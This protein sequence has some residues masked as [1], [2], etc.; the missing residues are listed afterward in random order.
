MRTACFRGLGGADSMLKTRTARRFFFFRVSRIRVK[1]VVQESPYRMIAVEPWRR[2]LTSQ[3]RE[4]A[5][6]CSAC[7]R[8]TTI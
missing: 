3:W 2:W 4:I 1:E 5:R 8:K 7:W 6:S